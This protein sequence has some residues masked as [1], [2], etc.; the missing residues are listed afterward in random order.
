MR[1]RCL[2]PAAVDPGNSQTDKR[3]ATAE[4]AAQEGKKSRVYMQAIGIQSISDKVQDVPKS[5]PA[6][7]PHC[8]VKRYKTEAKVRV[9]FEPGQFKDKYIDEYTGDVLEHSLIKAAIVE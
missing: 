4:D 6:E 7:I 3:T 2:L 1:R 5:E 9:Y 8:F